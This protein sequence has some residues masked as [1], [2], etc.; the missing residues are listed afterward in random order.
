M[1]V[2]CSLI[3]EQIK[4]AA[5]RA[6]EYLTG[7]S[8]FGIEL[9]CVSKEK[10]EFVAVKVVSFNESALLSSRVSVKINMI[11]QYFVGWKRK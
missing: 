11:E 7:P 5:T 1:R 2:S 10:L 3:L 8:K 9:K 4:D 6:Y